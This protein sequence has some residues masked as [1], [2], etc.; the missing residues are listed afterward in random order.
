MFYIFYRNLKE[1]DQECLEKPVVCDD[2]MGEVLRKNESKHASA[3]PMRFVCCEN[4]EGFYAYAQK[5]HR[6]QCEKKN[7]A[8]EYCKSELKGDDEKNTHLETCED[9]LIG[10]AFKEF[11]CN[12]EAPRKEMREH[13]K[14]PHNALLNQVILVSIRFFS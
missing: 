9:A 2:C 6:E 5:E 11:G 8:C 10:C 7:L 3:C 4:C 12:E 1:H 13:E 14:D